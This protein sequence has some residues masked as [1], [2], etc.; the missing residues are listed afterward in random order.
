M[1]HVQSEKMITREESILVVID[2]QEKLVPAVSDGKAMLDN[3]VR[4]VKFARIVRLPVVL[5]EQKKLGD[6]LAEVRSEL[7]EVDPV[8]KLT[9]DCFAEPA[10][11][12]RIRDLDR[13]TLIIAGI[14]AHIC[15]AQ[16]AISALG[17]FR[18]QVVGDAVSSRSPRN[19][20]FALDRMRQCGATV[21]TTEMAIYEL[22][23]RAG[24]D[25]FKAVLPLVK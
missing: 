19:C 21:T 9:F 20:A 3:I 6:T 2:V 11:A 5:T 13:R 17:D 1:Q 15:V 23:Q 16:T 18:V 14:E 10:F 22:L 7:P 4:L 25:E 24:T 8:Q 12:A